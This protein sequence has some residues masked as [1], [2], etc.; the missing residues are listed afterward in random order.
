MGKSRIFGV[1]QCA[2]ESRQDKK[3]LNPL[4]FTKIPPPFFY[5]RDG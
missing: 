3:K 2:F 1:L 5:E 4:N